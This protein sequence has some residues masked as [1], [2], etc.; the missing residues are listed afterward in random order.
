[1]AHN[2]LNRRS[3][4]HPKSLLNQAQVQ[5]SNLI[6]SFVDLATDPINLGAMALGTASFKIAKW[7]FLEGS[8]SLGL[9]KLA[10]KSVLNASSSIFALG[11]E[12]TSFRTG[13]HAL[14]KLA[15]RNLREDIFAS[16]AWLS[17]ALDLGALKGFGTLAA[18]TNLMLRNFIPSNA[19]VLAGSVSAEL[20][21]KSQEQGSYVQ[22]LAHAQVMFSALGAGMSFSGLMTGGRL[23]QREIHSNLRSEA[24]LSPVRNFTQSSVYEK[25]LLRMGAQELNRDPALLEVM[26]ALDKSRSNNGKWQLVASLGLHVAEVQ[27]YPWLLNSTRQGIDLTSR[28]GAPVVIT[29]GRSCMLHYGDALSWVGRTFHFIP[30]YESIPYKVLNAFVDLPSLEPGAV[31]GFDI[32]GRRLQIRYGEGKFYIRSSIAP[33]QLIGADGSLR[34]A[35]ATAFGLSDSYGNSGGYGVR[36]NNWLELKEGDW[37][38]VLGDNLFIFR[39]PLNTQGR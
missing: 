39:N 14:G 34:S 6:G 30:P 37:V 9:A 13:H 8:A 1:M 16:K 5:Q 4:L 22:R 31:K 24:H 12:V 19:M 27:Q 15:G 38:Q 20:E 21:L 3:I 25:S 33:M 32:Q 23:Q 2:L 18:G 28:Q 35:P 26:A 10:P 36:I 29:A 11:V 17:T 7:G